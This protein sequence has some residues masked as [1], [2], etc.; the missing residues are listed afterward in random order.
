MRRERPPRRKP[1]Q[2]QEQ[3]SEQKP[4]EQKDSQE[5]RQEITEQQQEEATDRE[6]PGQEDIFER[7][8][9]ATGLS[10]I[11][12]ILLQRIENFPSDEKNEL[13]YILKTGLEALEE[14]NEQE[15][16][17]T[18]EEKIQNIEWMS[19]SDK[20]Y[21]L[22]LIIKE[23]NGEKKLNREWFDNL[24]DYF[25]KLQKI[26][27]G[28]RNWKEEL[29]DIEDV[30]GF[31]YMS[32]SDDIVGDDTKKDLE[33]SFQKVVSQKD[34]VFLKIW[35]GIAWAVGGGLAGGLL[36]GAP[37]AAVGGAVGF[38]KGGGPEIDISLRSPRLKV[39]PKE[40]TAGEKLKRVKEV[41]ESFLKGKETRTFEFSEEFFE[42]LPE[43]IRQ[44]KDDSE[45]LKKFGIEKKGNKYE[46]HLN[47]EDIDRMLDRYFK[48]TTDVAKLEIELGKIFKEAQDLFKRVQ[49][50]TKDDPRLRE[51]LT[52]QL[53][54]ANERLNELLLQG[55]SKEELER[56]KKGLQEN[57]LASIEKILDTYGN[58]KLDEKSKWKKI[59]ELSKKMGKWS[60]ENVIVPGVS[61]GITGFLLWGAVMAFYLPVLIADYTQKKA[62]DFMK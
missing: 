27:E 19:D 51:L 35:P 23:E 59:G 30:K 47:K 15:I 56:V 38:M 28:G 58:K 29:D 22:N 54:V 62:G 32:M 46:I 52:Y 48:A 4:E 5:I 3:Q 33:A 21:I 8:G 1:E 36:G 39:E 49:K 40:L 6:T 57:L 26:E 2:K 17:R 25:E 53:R 42:R 31:L 9:F 24:K 10:G 16:I 41:L 61:L 50:E 37:G 20:Q 7:R 14:F 13:V 55:A 11:L 12:E 60:W 18:I 34:P 43:E 45:E 44:H